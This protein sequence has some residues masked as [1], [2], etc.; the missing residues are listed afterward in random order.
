MIPVLA[1]VHANVALARPA[2]AGATVRR[3]GHRHWRDQR[4]S[5]FGWLRRL[6][7]MR[8]LLGER[9]RLS[10]GPGWAADLARV[11]EHPPD[12][13]LPP[14]RRRSGRARPLS[15]RET[16]RAAAAERISHQ[17]RKSPAIDAS[18]DAAARASK[19][20]L[21]VSLARQVPSGLLAGLAGEPRRP[22]S[23]QVAAS[24][25]GRRR[26]AD[27]APVG[28]GRNALPAWRERLQAR[29]DD[30]LL[31]MPGGAG[32]ATTASPAS[33]WKLDL[34]GERFADALLAGLLDRSAGARPA[35]RMAA[36]D[37][38]AANVSAP[39][40]NG[41]ARAAAADGRGDAARPA[42][43]GDRLE[44]G[45][46]TVESR[47]ADALAARLEVG[48]SVNRTLQP[49]DAR[50]IDALDP[51]FTAAGIDLRA[52]SELA[53]RTENDADGRPQLALPPRRPLHPALPGSAHSHTGADLAP[54]FIDD[55]DLARRLGRILRDEARRHGV[56]V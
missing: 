33:P 44:T 23:A 10:G 43:S 39:R 20:P 6:T 38:H 50:D 2:G 8:R 16:R 40:G 54:A 31:R 41:Q 47:L 42:A 52:P 13:T 12:D 14:P 7:W 18:P 35:R 34:A 49:R 21:P 26:L 5:W 25:P 22:S 56:D 4:E 46:G 55:R 29:L 28:P 48:W 9:P 1:A 51:V 3:W 37:R 27:P 32:P 53:A 30:R 45:P 19:P 36:V 24:A 15:Q 11:L 17:E